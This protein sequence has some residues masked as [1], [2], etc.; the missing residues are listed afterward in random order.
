MNHVQDAGVCIESIYVTSGLIR[1]I[2][3]IFSL[4]Y[5]ALC[6]CKPDG[7]YE[8]LV[9]Y[10]INERW[11]DK[12]QNEQLKIAY[13]KQIILT[14]TPSVDQLTKQDKVEIV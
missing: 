6:Q 2:S 9:E 11:R 7:R 3:N 8:R 14:E 1:Y 13:E 5:L 10:L 12:P 4:Y